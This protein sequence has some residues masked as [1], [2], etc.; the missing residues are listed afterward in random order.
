ML[1]LSRKNGERV[2]FRLPSGDKIW[3]SVEFVGSHNVK[4][5]IDAPDNVEILREELVKETNGTPVRN[6]R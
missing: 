2:C 4:L 1:V 3:I 5:G 6:R